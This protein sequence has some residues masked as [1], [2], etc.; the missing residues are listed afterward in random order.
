M[1]AIYMN[2]FVSFISRIVPNLEDDESPTSKTDSSDTS[3]TNDANNDLKSTTHQITKLQ[4]LKCIQTE[5]PEDDEIGD[6][7]RT[8]KTANTQ[9]DISQQINSE[10]I[11][12]FTGQV[13]RRRRKLPEIP[14][15]K[16][17]KLS[18]L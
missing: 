4:N 13:E 17:C 15:N 14:K 12:T 6:G 11:Q 7:L 8:K 9:T 16:R 10:R 5:S 1:R 3:I 2:L 18:P